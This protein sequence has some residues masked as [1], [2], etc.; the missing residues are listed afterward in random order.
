MYCYHF[1]NLATTVREY[2]SLRMSEFYGMAPI[3]LNPSLSLQ[4]KEQ[5]L[6]VHTKE[7]EL[8]LG[9]HF[10][11]IKSEPM[12]YAK[13]VA[14]VEDQPTR[15][16]K[17]IKRNK[18]LFNPSQL[19]VLDKV[20]EM[21]EHDIMLIQGPPGTGKTHT[22]TGIISMLLSCDIKRIMV[23]APS[24]AA[25]DEIITRIGSKGFVGSPDNKDLDSILEEGY[26]AEG[27][28]VR[29]GSLEYDPGPEVKKHTLDERLTQTM[30]G[31]KAFDLKQ[32]IACCQELLE[33]LSVEENVNT[34]KG[35]L[36]LESKKHV[37]HLMVL[38]FQSSSRVKE[39]VKS[40]TKQ[41]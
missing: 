38:F 32:K 28:I 40:N 17:Y 36:T 5:M 26:S 2:K 30:N 29:L 22:I 1:E 33:D 24:N 11:Q 19:I 35:F 27:L 37:S 12:K 13:N 39:F 3:L 31:N 21:P 18:K 14:V 6:Q 20:T 15:M 23:C 4:N 16:R 10:K 25:I 9:N 7:L 8:A 34:C 41:E